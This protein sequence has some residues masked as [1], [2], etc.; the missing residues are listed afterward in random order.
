MCPIQGDRLRSLTESIL[1]LPH[2]Q[3]G[4]KAQDVY[5]LVSGSAGIT[6]VCDTAYN[7]TIQPHPI[8][9]KFS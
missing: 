6:R 9:Q 5:E 2:D 4:F 3:S 8:S 1:I 7:V